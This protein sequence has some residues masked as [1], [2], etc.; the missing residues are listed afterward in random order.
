[1]KIGKCFLERFNSKIGDVSSVNQLQESS[2]VINVL[3]RAVINVLG[4]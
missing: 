2:A 1:M 3:L 4:T